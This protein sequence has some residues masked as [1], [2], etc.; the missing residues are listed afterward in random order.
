MS[1]YDL[2][3]SLFVVVLPKS[4]NMKQP[5]D[6]SP[7]D[8]PP[9]QPGLVWYAE[10]RRVVYD[11]LFAPLLVV[12]L[13]W[14]QSAVELW[15]PQHADAGRFPIYATLG[16]LA[17]FYLAYRIWCISPRLIFLS[18]VRRQEQAVGAMLESLNDLGYR[19]FHDVVGPGFKIDHVLI[20]P[21]GIFVAETA[22]LTRPTRAEARLFFDGQSLHVSDQPP[23]PAP[24]SRVKAQARWLSNTLTEANDY[25]LKVS[26]LVLASG[27]S[28]EQ[29]ASLKPEVPVLN[30]MAVRDYLERLA[31]SFDANTINQA[32]LHLSEFVRD[33]GRRISLLQKTG[34]VL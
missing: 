30:S 18:R 5:G 1:C 3:Q 26:P 27:W 10:T 22:C 19:V 28:I 11:E 4:T 16:T 8:E 13:L 33:T 24:V 7:I 32:T 34:E 20:G 25:W 15:D 21:A 31:L 29:P 2:I 23:D 6:M 14:V 17:T 12:I 9:D